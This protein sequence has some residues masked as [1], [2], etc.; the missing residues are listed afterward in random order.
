MD[1]NETYYSNH[2]ANYI[3]ISNHVVHV[4][5]NV[6]CQLFSVKLEKKFNCIEKKEVYMHT[7]S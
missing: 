5:Y 7:S 1:V 6:I 4:K 3:Y 2:L